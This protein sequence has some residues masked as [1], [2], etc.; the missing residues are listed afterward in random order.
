M[1]QNR[2]MLHS[3]CLKWFGPTAQMDMQNWANLLGCDWNR[4]I[5]YLKAQAIPWNIASFHKVTS[6]VTL[7]LFNGGAQF[8]LEKNIY[9]RPKPLDKFYSRLDLWHLI[10]IVIRSKDLKLN[11]FKLSCESKLFG[12]WTVQICT[13]W[14]AKLGCNVLT[15]WVW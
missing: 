9:F 12:L 15:K 10:C 5:S 3:L 11:K 6:L 1:H 4:R 13:I 2:C 14:R 7:L 8:S